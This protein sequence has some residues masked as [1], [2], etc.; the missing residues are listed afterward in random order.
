MGWVTRCEFYPDPKFFTD[1]KLYDVKSKTT[2]GDKKSKRISWRDI[3][4]EFRGR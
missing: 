1:I 4:D 3:L 2:H